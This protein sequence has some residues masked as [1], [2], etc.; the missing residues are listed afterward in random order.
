VSNKRASTATVTAIQGEV[1]EDTPSVPTKDVT[2]QSALIQTDVMTSAVAVATE[3][4]DIPA[5]RNIAS[6]AAGLQKAAKSRG[7]GIAQE[8]RAAE[9]VLRAERGIG[10]A[11]IHMKEEG[12]R[13]G[14]GQWRER[15]VG[16]KLRSGA[17]TE[18]AVANSNSLITLD[19]LGIER[20]TASRFQLLARLSDEDFESLVSRRRES[21]ERIAKVDFYRLA[22]EVASGGTPP[23]DRVRAVKDLVGEEPETLAFVAFRKAAGALDISQLAQEEVI[24][25]ADII[26]DLANRYNVERNRRAA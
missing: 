9:V 2:P 17:A 21:D 22:K 19:D 12:L 7:V 13:A 24:E 20:T 25:L 15:P 5:L 18:Q 6:M 8:N 11:L 10:A 1:L 14:D 16:S 23:A 3:E 26:K 4:G